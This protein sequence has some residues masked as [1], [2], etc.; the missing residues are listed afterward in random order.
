MIPGF[1]AA[2]V[3]ASQRC[4][5]V[6]RLRQPPAPLASL[7]LDA[8]A[9][10]TP[11]EA[12]AM[13]HAVALDAHQRNAARRS[14][15]ISGLLL[16]VGLMGAIDTIVFHQLLQW[17]HLYVHTTAFWRIFSDGLIH[18][19][20]TTLLLLGALR[21]WRDRRLLAGATRA[22]LLGAT[23]L[24]MGG[25]QIFDGTVFHK[26]LHVHPVREGVANLLPYDLA[27]NLAGLALWIAGVLIWRRAAGRGPDS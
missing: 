27:W 10:A 20:T 11:L 15:L 24:G 1:G 6:A 23:L 9:K 25:F 13:T 7:L 3:T 14:I 22:D 17:H 16:G 26:V 2:R 21:L 19:G 12:P 5:V 18:I 4:V 8:A